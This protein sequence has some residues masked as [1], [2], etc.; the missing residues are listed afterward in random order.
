MQ[1]NLLTPAPFVCLHPPRLP[2]PNPPFKRTH[3]GAADEICLY[4]VSEGPRQPLAAI[5][6]TTAV[7]GGPFPA[8][9]G[10][11]WGRGGA[12]SGTASGFSRVTFRGL[13]ELWAPRGTMGRAFTGKRKEQPYFGGSRGGRGVLGGGCI[14]GGSSWRLNSVAA[15][16]IQKE[17]E[18]PFPC[19]PG[20][21]ARENIPG[22]PG[23]VWAET[24]GCG[25]PWCSGCC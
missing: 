8:A 2:A 11:G 19:L 13:S 17:A 12:H 1:S 22:S 16:L 14:D 24:P 15:L 21:Q 7:R 20:P 18:A 25:S 3:S 5:L 23:L 9:G 10:W 4:L 6:I